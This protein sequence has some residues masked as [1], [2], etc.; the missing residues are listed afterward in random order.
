MRK[1][2][3]VGICPSST[4]VQTIFPIESGELLYYPSPELSQYWD[5]QRG[6]PL[7]KTHWIPNGGPL[8]NHHELYEKSFFSFRLAAL[9]KKIKGASIQPVFCLNVLTRNL[10]DQLEMLRKAEEYG[11]PV[12]YIQ[13]G[14]NLAAHEVDAIDRFPTAVDYA[15]EMYAWATQL[16][17]AFPKA[18][19]SLS[20]GTAFMDDPRG[21]PWSKVLVDASVEAKTSQLPL[22]M[23]SL[24]PP[25]MSYEDYQSVFLADATN[26]AEIWLTIEESSPSD[27]SARYEDSS[28][29]ALTAITRRMNLLENQQITAWFLTLDNLPDSQLDEFMK[30]VVKNDW[31]THLRFD[32]L[33]NYTPGTTSQGLS[34]WLFSDGQTQEAWV[35]NTHAFP[36]HLSEIGWKAYELEGQPVFIPGNSLV[37][38]TNVS[39]NNS[40]KSFPKP[41]MLKVVPKSSSE[42]LQ[43]EFQSEE[44]GIST[45]LLSSASGQIIWRKRNL[46]IQPGFNQIQVYPPSLSSGTYFM[47]LIHKG[48]AHTTRLS[49]ND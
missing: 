43:M 3:K 44:S 10:P 8:Q 19:V 14:H 15:I 25:E 18:Q 20:G 34:G 23:S 6:L 24:I 40:V 9:A 4:N 22:R 1:L 28:P 5:W 27:E 26:K 45:L 39:F 47:T 32:L 35:V 41:S 30:S 2:P 31:G 33:S 42:I 13:L 46:S 38:F 48:N 37:H 21:Q 36:I 7:D 17:N 16:Q 11:I 49:I 12:R 29:N